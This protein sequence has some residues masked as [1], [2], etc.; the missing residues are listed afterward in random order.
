MKLQNAVTNQFH[1]QH[2]SFL[3]AIFLHGLLLAAGVAR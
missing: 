1:Y 2:V 3:T